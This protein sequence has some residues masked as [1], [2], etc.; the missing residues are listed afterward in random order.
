MSIS[1][2][3][4]L[5]SAIQRRWSGKPSVKARPYIESFFSRT[6]SAEKIA[7]Q[8]EGNHGTYTVPI[9]LTAMV[10]QTELH[11][12]SNPDSGASGLMRS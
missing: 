5:R 4:Q 6:R 10:A 2:N 7:A 1:D 11:C 8:V 3:A 12:D 9:E